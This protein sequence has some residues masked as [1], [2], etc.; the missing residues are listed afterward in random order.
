[1]NINGAIG[2]ECLQPVARFGDTIKAASTIVL[3]QQLEAANPQAERIY[4]I[5]GNAAR[6][7]R[8]KEVT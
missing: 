6:Y 3:F 5:C 8:S 2:L 7:Y 4:V 1:L